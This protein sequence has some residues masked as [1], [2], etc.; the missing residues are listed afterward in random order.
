MKS[1]NLQKIFFVERNY[2]GNSESFS[3]RKRSLDIYGK[4]DEIMK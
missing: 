2:A 1:M 4:A 3:I